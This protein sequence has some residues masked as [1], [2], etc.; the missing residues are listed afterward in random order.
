MK[1]MEG[2]T[3]MMNNE[4]IQNIEYLREK[5]NV[6]YEEATEHLENNNGDVMHAMIELEKQGRLFSQT[7]DRGD[8]RIEQQFHD[9][10]IEAK[11]KAKSFFEKAKQTRLVIERKNQYGEKETV[12]NVSALVAGCATVVAPHLTIA[13]GLLSLVTGHQ[14]KVE[15]K[16]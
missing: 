14:V 13:A 3:T 6:S 5:A 15:R 11:G 9:E 2:E 10:L 4:M 16:D 7:D 8:T 1:I 12:A